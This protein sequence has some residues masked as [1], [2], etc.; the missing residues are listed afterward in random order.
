MP[1][2]TASRRRCPRLDGAA[3]SFSSSS[4]FVRGMNVPAGTIGGG[5]RVGVR[6]AAAVRQDSRSNGL[7]AILPQRSPTHR[8]RGTDHG[9]GVTA[10]R[11]VPGSGGVGKDQG[12]GEA[13]WGLRTVRGKATAHRPSPLSRKR[14]GVPYTNGFRGAPDTRSVPVSVLSTVSRSTR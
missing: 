5:A 2:D 9:R 12:E 6:R 10:G 14:S 7:Q 1:Y 4:L 8:L 13:L 11:R 3:R